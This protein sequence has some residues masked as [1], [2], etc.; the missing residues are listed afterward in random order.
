[1]RRRSKL[2]T[3]LTVFCVTLLTAGRV[4]VAKDGSTAARPN[5]VVLMVD[6]LG[7]NHISAE[8][9]TLGTSDKLYQTPH[10]AQL[11]KDGMSFPFAYAQPNCAPTRAAM[12]SGQY[13]PRV[14]NSV[15]VVGNLN[16]FGRGGIKKQQAKFEGPEQS[17]DVSAEAVTVAES[18]Q[19]NGYATAHIG[20]YHV[21]GHEGDATLPENSGFD[22]NIGGFSQGHQPVCFA[23]EGKNGWTFKN[24]GRGDF[25]RFAEPY[26]AEYVKR[27]QLPQQLVGTPKHVSDAIGDAMEET[28]QKL[29][30]GDKPFYLQFHTYAVHGP[31]RARPDLKQEVA[32]R[33]D[34]EKMTEYAAFISSV[35]ENLGRLRSLLN[36]PNQD[37]DSS[38]SISEQTLILFTSDNGGTHASNAPL[39]G[40]KGEFYEG[41]IRVPLIACWPGTIQADS[42]N[43]RLVHCVDYYPTFLELAGNQWQPSQNVHPLD[44]ESFSAALHGEKSAARSEPIFFLFPGY[45]DQRAQP[46][47]VVI[48]E[49]DGKRYKLTY[50]YERDAWELYCLSDDQSEANELSKAQPEIARQLASVIRKWLQQKHPTWQPQ[51]PILRKTGKPAGPPPEFATR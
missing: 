38:D 10:I 1:M 25:D 28:V 8:Q 45:L 41:G 14:H 2:I 31:V 43:N 12:L 18:L 24:L 4:T 42:V 36:D 32:K 50:Y 16:R 13:P 3:W 21:G 5:I 30:D 44:G 37:G 9:A 27:R 46:C 23:S 34:Q 40:E 48:D 6:D 26:S 29:A 15:Y 7:W 47:A 17:E 49:I 19:R 35:D 39:R 20:K 22:I 11:A 51:Y 33:N